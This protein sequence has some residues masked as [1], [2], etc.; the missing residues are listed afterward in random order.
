VVI[1]HS[2]CAYVDKTQRVETG[3]QAI[4]ERTKLLHQVSM[5]DTSFGFRDL[6][7]KLMSW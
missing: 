2:C 1:N 7:E 5:N 3:I 6:W 4:W